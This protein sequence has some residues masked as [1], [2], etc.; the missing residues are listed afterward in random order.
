MPSKCIFRPLSGA[1][2][3]MASSAAAHQTITPVSPCSLL[4]WP[5]MQLLTVLHA[6]LAGAL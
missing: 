1:A 5:S 4:I 6:G 3:T 2:C